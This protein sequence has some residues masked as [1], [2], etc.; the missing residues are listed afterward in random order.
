MTAGLQTIVY[1]VTDLVK[2]K[3]LF[4]ALFDAE[5]TADTPYYVGYRVAGQDIGLDPNGHEKKGMTAPVGYWHVEDIENRLAALVEAG[6]TITQE[7]TD[8]GGGKLIATVTDADGN[9]IGLLQP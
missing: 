6:A 3:S 4:G 5:P 7:P 1:P 8:V 2:A 9:T